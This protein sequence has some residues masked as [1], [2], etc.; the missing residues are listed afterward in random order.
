MNWSMFWRGYVY[1]WAFVG[2]VAVIVLCMLIAS[3]T[4]APPPADVCAVMRPLLPIDLT[5]AG[6]DAL[7][8]ADPQGADR[9]DD[10]NEWFDVRCAGE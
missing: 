5:Q 7:D 9:I 3:C 1:G 8:A 10:A 6:W 2:H 4:A